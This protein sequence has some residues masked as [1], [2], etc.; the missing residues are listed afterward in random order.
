[1][2][3]AAQGFN[4]RSVYILSI[5]VLVGAF[6]Y[7]DRNLPWPDGTADPCRHRAERYG[8]RSH[9]GFRLRPVLFAGRCA[10]RGALGQG[11]TAQRDRR[12]L[13]RLDHH[14]H[15]Y[16]RG[17]QRLAARHHTVSGRRRRSVR[18]RSRQR[19]DQRPLQSPFAWA[20]PV[21]LFRG[22]IGYQQHR[23]DSCP[24]ASRANASGGARRS[25]LRALRVSSS[26]RSSSP[27]RNCPNETLVLRALRPRTREA[28]ST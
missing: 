9:F 10:R 27:S 19:I 12:R 11:R 8:L 1:M 22:F 4:R 25:S 6:N 24:R 16:R 13:L 17:D 15:A 3:D 26:P 18:Q 23:A 5:I 20:R 2:S 7:F 21:D 28:S 14:D